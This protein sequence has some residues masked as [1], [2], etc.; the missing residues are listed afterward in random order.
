VVETQF[1]HRSLSTQPFGTA[2]PWLGHAV[3]G[4]DRW[5]RRRQ[6]V[7]E[8]TN[9]ENCLFRLQRVEAEGPLTLRDGTAIARGDPLL[10]LHLWNEHIPPMAPGG[11]TVAWARQTGHAL[12]LSLRDL[13]GYLA[14]DPALDDVVA[15]RADLWL[16]TAEYNAKLA[17]IMAHCGFEQPDTESG[18]S[19]PLHRFGENILIFLLVMATNP[20]AIR[21]PGLPR[22]HKPVYL[23][24][25]ALERRYAPRVNSP[26]RTG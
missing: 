21:V 10:A 12:N 4:L 25:A 9:D 1:L 19:G 7:Y 8:Y 26:A 20:A 3:L 14:A 16:G 15:I 24:R 23:S 5:L 11:P 18:T 6:G 13:V 17:R 22:E 2:G